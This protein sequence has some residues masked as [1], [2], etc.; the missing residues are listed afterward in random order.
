MTRK[1]R[2]IYL[3]LTL[4]IAL[5]ALSYA[6]MTD[7]DIALRYQAK[8]YLANKSN[9]KEIKRSIH[10]AMSAV[11]FNLNLADPDS[12]D[13][14]DVAIHNNIAI[15]C[16]YV[17]AKNSMGDYTGFRRFYVIG[18]V[19]SGKGRNDTHFEGEPILGEYIFD[20]MWDNYCT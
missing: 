16:G 9:A 17:S 3:A 20:S 12:A 11:K 1:M 13:F 8:A 10:N 14:K 4:S 5:P 18:A 6:Q 2:L 19:L 15:V 7:E